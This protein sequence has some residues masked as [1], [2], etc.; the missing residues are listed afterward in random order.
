MIDEILISYGGVGV[1]ALVLIIQNQ[2][3]MHKQDK[4][5]ER[6]ASVVENNTKMMA[7]FITI[8]KERR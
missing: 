1:L 4:R 8:F 5:E 2:R 3:L 6:L 7:T